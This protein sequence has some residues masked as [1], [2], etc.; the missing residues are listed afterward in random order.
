MSSKVI[1]HEL[2]EN[3]SS[4]HWKDE[5]ASKKALEHS[6]LTIKSSKR[7]QC[8]GRCRKKTRFA[9]RALQD[10]ASS[11]SAPYAGAWADRELSLVCVFAPLSARPLRRG[12]PLAWASALSGS[13]WRAVALAFFSSSSEL[14][15]VFAPLS[16]PWRRGRQPPSL[17]VSLFLY[18]F[19]VNLPQRVPSQGL[20]SVLPRAQFET[21]I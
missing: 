18:F 14:S 5:L 8:R 20:L 3:L 12:R 17:P 10:A 6:H 13:L 1:P 21:R 15:C 4:P 7:K 11:F 19:R 2:W 16:V 9:Q